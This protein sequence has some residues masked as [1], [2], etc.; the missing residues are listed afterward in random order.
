MKFI[1]T[2]LKHLCASTLHV[3]VL[4]LFTTVGEMN[5]LDISASVN[6]S[7][8]TWITNRVV[9]IYSIHVKLLFVE[10]SLR[11]KTVSRSIYNLM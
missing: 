7:P 10:G 4:L 1:F 5:A 9:H 11:L 2:E 6:N 3:V 8:S